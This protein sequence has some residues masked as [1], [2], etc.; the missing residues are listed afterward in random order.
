MSVTNRTQPWRSVGLWM[1]GV[2]I[3][4]ILFNA[5]RSVMNPVEFAS[6][7]GLPLSDGDSTVFV[8]VYAI[9]AV[10]LGVFGLAL[11]IRRQYSALTLYALVAAVMPLGDALLV[12]LEGG[13]AGIMIRHLLTA[14]FLLGTAFMV[15]RYVK[16]NKLG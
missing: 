4:Y 5:L 15:S 10:F 6:Y 9:R 12:A 11:L 1:V 2:L 16:A 7:Y 13:G 3:V 14:L 8:L